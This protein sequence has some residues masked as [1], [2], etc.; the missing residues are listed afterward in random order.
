MLSQV[1]EVEIKR[2]ASKIPVNN[3]SGKN[4]IIKYA[5]ISIY[6]NSKNSSGENVTTIIY[7]KVRLVDLF[8]ANMLLKTDIIIPEKI[9]LLLSRKEIHIKSCNITVIID[10]KPRATHLSQ[11]A[12][13]RSNITMPIYT[14]LT[15]SVKNQLSIN[16]DFIFMPKN[17]SMSVFYYIIDSN[18]GAILIRNKFNIF[19][20]FKKNTRLNVFT[21]FNDDKYF[22]V[23]ITEY[24]LTLK[25]IKYTK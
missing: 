4:T 13:V 14:Q 22:T 11:A 1:P 9:D 12:R 19:I 7:T 16:R 2:M 6:I 21:E 3:I 23:K 17:A 20:I 24:N 25:P 5:V 18:T 15:V 10:A 8:K